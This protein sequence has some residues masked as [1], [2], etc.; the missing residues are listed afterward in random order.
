MSI[1]GKILADVV[2]G[3]FDVVDLGIGITKDVVKSPIRALDKLTLEGNED[4][5]EDTQEAIERIKE[6]L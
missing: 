5:T 6:E 2:E 3:A 1:F 4:F